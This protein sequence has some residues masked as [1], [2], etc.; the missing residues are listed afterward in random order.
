MKKVI[1][2]L[3]L[4]F[5]SIGQP[6]F[7]ENLIDI[8]SM[9][10]S[11]LSL[12]IDSIR[13]VKGYVTA[14]L[15]INRQRTNFG[16]MANCQEGTISDDFGTTKS[17]EQWEFNKPRFDIEENAIN[18][19]C[20]KFKPIRSINYIYDES[21]RSYASTGKKVSIHYSGQWSLIERGTTTFKEVSK[22]STASDMQHV[23]AIFLLNEGNSKFTV[24]SLEIIPL[25]LTTSTLVDYFKKKGL[26]CE[27]ALINGKEGVQC[28]GKQRIG[29]FEKVAVITNYAIG[30]NLVA[31][32]TVRTSENFLDSKRDE[33][34][35]LV[36]SLS[37]D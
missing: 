12:D 11:D 28:I 14:D 22:N 18:N 6:A 19:L 24:G 16:L 29:F 27:I 36:N 20:R 8:G 2:A 3:S 15:F 31:G 17:P 10:G 4:F 5:L 34:M 33:I 1:F 9:R 7:S 30:N 37:I 32:M 23:E 25:N 26:D 13:Y 21:D 35:K